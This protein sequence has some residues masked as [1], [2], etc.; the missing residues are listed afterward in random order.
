MNTGRVVLDHETRVCELDSGL[1]KEVRGLLKALEALD[2][3]SSSSRS[4]ASVGPC[5]ASLPPYASRW[6][7]IPGSPTGPCRDRL[8]VIIDNIDTAPERIGEALVHVGRRCLGITRTVV[9]AVVV[10]V[11]PFLGCWYL[12][13][14]SFSVLCEQFDLSCSLLFPHAKH[15]R[16]LHA[17]EVFQGAGG[18]ANR[19]GILLPKIIEVLDTD[20]ESMLKSLFAWAE[21]PP[22]A[23]TLEAFLDVFQAILGADGDMG[24]RI[25]RYLA[26]ASTQCPRATWEGQFRRIVDIIEQP[27]DGDEYT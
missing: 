1:Y 27:F 19:L 26:T 24:E 18:K 2:P 23:G 25:R 7:I 11:F 20:H 16:I 13:Q 14:P 10:D 9:F 12:Y 22:G 8:L 15:D 17:S 5:N 4:A 3:V 6:N 21:A